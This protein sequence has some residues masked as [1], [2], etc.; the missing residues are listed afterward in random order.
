M[1]DTGMD[2]DNN[3]NNIDHNSLTPMMQQFLRLKAEQPDNL[4]FYRM[5]DFY[6]LFFQDAVDAANLLDITLTA[7]GQVNGKPI[8]MCGVPFH[9]VER[10]LARLV[11]LGRSVAICEQIGDPATSKGPVERQIVR[12]VTPGTV[13]D[14]A[15][16][17]ERSDCILMALSIA[18][19]DNSSVRAGLAWMDISGGRFKVCEVRGLNDLLAEIERIKPAELLVNEHMLLPAELDNRPGLRRRP[20]WEFD[21][22]TCYRQ[23]TSHFQ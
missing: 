19:D 4:L 10:Y 17:K 20:V 2:T 16:L 18:G 23:L 1:P 21:S 12:I 6:E 5:G 14:E 15:L 8:P 7:R 11:E 13:S 3:V 22:D 9:S